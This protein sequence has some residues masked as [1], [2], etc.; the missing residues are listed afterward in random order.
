MPLFYVNMSDDGAQRYHM[1]NNGKLVVCPLA[2]RNKAENLELALQGKIQTA[3]RDVDCFISP[4]PAVLHR[5][6]MIMKKADGGKGASKG[7]VCAQNS[8][9]TVAA[10]KKMIHKT[11]DKLEL[12]QG[13]GKG[14]TKGT[15]CDVYE[16]IMRAQ[17]PSNM[18]RPYQFYLRDTTLPIT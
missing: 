8:L 10:L 17:R 12:D 2:H 3:F 15:L 13:K 5:F 4:D 16:I 6:K 11:D 7:S 18:A 9:L 14:F 1:F